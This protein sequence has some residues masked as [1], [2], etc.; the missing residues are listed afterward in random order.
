MK[1]CGCEGTY[2]VC[3]GVGP[4][5]GV[6]PV[7]GLDVTDVSR[8]EETVLT[9]ALQILASLSKVGPFCQLFFF[10][11]LF[12]LA[13]CLVCSFKPF[14]QILVPFFLNHYILS[15]K[16]LHCICLNINQLYIYFIVWIFAFAFL[17]SLSSFPLKFVPI[18]YFFLF[19]F[20]FYPAVLQLSS[21]LHASL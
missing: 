11:F 9:P 6:P 12:F 15:Y 13:L 20:L 2:V 3:V 5:D 16:C 21:S 1:V 19:P 17:F 14:F 7:Y 10:F 4:G 8:W 18:D